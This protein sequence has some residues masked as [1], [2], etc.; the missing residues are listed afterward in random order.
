KEG[1]ICV[2]A[3]FICGEFSAA[4]RVADQNVRPP[5]GCVFVRHSDFVIDS[6]FG[7]CHSPPPR[8]AAFFRPIVS[9]SAPPDN[10]S[11]YW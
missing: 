8:A 1:L 9:A 11:P 4:Q 6:G 2:H 10:P 3:L 5:G 7:F